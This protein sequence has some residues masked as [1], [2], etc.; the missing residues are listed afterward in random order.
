MN[1]RKTVQELAKQEIY[2]KPHL[3]ASSMT[4]I[5][6]PLKVKLPNPD[7]LLLLCHNLEQTKRLLV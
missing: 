3:I 4:S 7:S 2:Q 6:T 5:F 1:V